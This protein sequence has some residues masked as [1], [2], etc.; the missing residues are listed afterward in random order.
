MAVSIQGDDPYAD[1][2]TKAKADKK[3]RVQKNLK[4]KQQNAGE[5]S[6]EEGTTVRGRFDSLG[7][8]GMGIVYVTVALDGSLGCGGNPSV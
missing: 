1:P 6:G 8:Y 7:I 2:W 4:Q 3:A 5:T